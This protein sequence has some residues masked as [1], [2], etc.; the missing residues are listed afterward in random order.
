L[1]VRG[2][3]ADNIRADLPDSGQE[4]R[5]DRSGRDP[6]LEVRLD[7]VLDPIRDRRPADDDRDAGAVTIEIER[8]FGGGVLPADHD[9][10]PPVKRIARDVTR[11]D[12]RL[13]LA[14]NAQPPRVRKEARSQDR[15]R[16][17]EPL[18]PES[19]LC[20]YDHAAAGARLDAFDLGLGTDANA[21]PLRHPAVVGERLETRRVSLRRR[22]RHARDV[23]QVARGEPAH[24]LRKV[25]DR[26]QDRSTIQTD[27]SDAST[28]Q[29]DGTG[30][31]GGPGADDGDRRRTSLAAHRD[32]PAESSA[33]GYRAPAR[34]TKRSLRRFAMSRDG[35][36]PTTIR[37]AA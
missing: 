33:I 1:P 25:V 29:L 6:I 30:D 2:R 16:S 5:G 11:V 32:A 31:P 37:S 3:D 27:R 19:G 8:G 21:K 22:E 34:M 14:R 20:R 13:I 7:P 12:V 24:L 4:E 23:E 17:I 35:S 15:R 9:H 18:G 28:A 10:V 26:I 36:A